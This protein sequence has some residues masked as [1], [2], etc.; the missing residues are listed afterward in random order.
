MDCGKKDSTQRM[1]KTQIKGVE[2]L[3]IDRFLWNPNSA[4]EQSNWCFSDMIYRIDR[5][6]FII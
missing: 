1:R 6:R 4:G 2:I 5:M 3:A